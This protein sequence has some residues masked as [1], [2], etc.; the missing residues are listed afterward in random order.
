[1]PDVTVPDLGAAV[2]WLQR[3]GL[4][5]YR[6]SYANHI[7][8]EDLFAN[9]LYC[10]EVVAYSW[11]TGRLDVQLHLRPKRG[12]TAETYFANFQKVGKHGFRLIGTTLDL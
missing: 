10:T 1:M 12:G 4:A 2:E 5:A 3:S 9:K 6:R 8:A 11:P 7:A